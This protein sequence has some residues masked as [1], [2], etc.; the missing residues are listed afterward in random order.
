MLDREARGPTL[1]EPTVEGG[2]G[3]G[4]VDVDAGASDPAADGVGGGP[5]ARRVAGEVAAD[6]V[7]AEGEESLKLGVARRAQG[8]VADD[9]I[10]VEGLEVAEVEDQSVPVAS[11]SSCSATRSPRC[12]S[13]EPASAGWSRSAS[14]GVPAR[15]RSTAWIDRR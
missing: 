10:A 15:S 4:P 12:N 8:A 1:G 3:E 7:D 11:A 9:E 6:G 2:R 13:T 5:V 14:R